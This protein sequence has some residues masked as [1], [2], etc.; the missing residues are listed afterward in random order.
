MPTFMSSNRI[1]LFMSWARL[2]YNSLV[3]TSM[4]DLIVYM[5]HRAN[6][7]WNTTFACYCLVQ[8]A[9][10]REKKRKKRRTDCRVNASGTVMFR[11]VC[12]D[13]KMYR[14]E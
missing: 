6:Y 9:N 5:S 10:K 11:I 2:I 4:Y 12:A 13:E 7:L 1:G 3:Y 14:K 8:I